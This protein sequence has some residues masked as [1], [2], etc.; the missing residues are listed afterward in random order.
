[1]C[2]AEERG[3]REEGEEGRPCSQEG[4]GGGGVPPAWRVWADVHS[5]AGHLL[6]AVEQRQQRQE[7]EED[8]QGQ[9]LHQLRW[10]YGLYSHAV[11]G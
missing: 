1:M 3:R 2:R 4:L 8:T 7:T 9:T 10:S 11:D 6:L 5:N